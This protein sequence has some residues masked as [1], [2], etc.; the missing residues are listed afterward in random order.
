MSPRCGFAVIP[1]SRK[2]SRRQVANIE[3]LLERRTMT[4]RDIARLFGVSEN[5]VWKIGKSAGLTRRWSRWTEEEDEFL[6]RNY[7]KHGPS[8]LVKFFPRHPDSL[9]IAVRAHKLGLKADDP[10]RFGR[11]S[12]RLQFRVIDGGASENETEGHRDSP[13]VQHQERH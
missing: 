12:R 5:T 11:H 1:M 13:G 7:A 3:S 6:R 10:N 4:Y 2:L 9:S 8:A